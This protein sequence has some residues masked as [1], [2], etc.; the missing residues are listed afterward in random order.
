MLR[1]RYADVIAFDS[2]DDDIALEFSGIDVAA[3]IEW[4][5]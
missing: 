2:E 1:G 3:G 4:H 5:F